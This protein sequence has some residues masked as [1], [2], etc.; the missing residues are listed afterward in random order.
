M[1]DGD[2]VALARERGFRLVLAG[3][4]FLL[5]VVSAQAA[6]MLIGS[7]S[8]LTS[9][10][11]N[12]LRNAVRYT[13]DGTEVAVSLTNGDGNA[14]LSIIDHGGG[15]PEGELSNLFRPFYRVGEA[16]DRGSG[17]G[18]FLGA[19]RF[20]RPDCCRLTPAATLVGCSPDSP[21]PWR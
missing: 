16:R 12:V 14:R 18:Q 17:G 20:H 5:F 3:M 10:V 15:V 21:P 19:R 6:L 7:E 2:R 1:S 11:E 13:R 9:A 8:L 4:A